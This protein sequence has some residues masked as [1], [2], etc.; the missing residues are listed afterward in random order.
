MICLNPSQNQWDSDIDGMSTPT[1]LFDWNFRPVLCQSASKWIFTWRVS[2]SL[3][4]TSGWISPVQGVFVSIKACHRTIAA[5]ASPSSSSSSV[6]APRVATTTS[7]AA[8]GRRSNGGDMKRSGGRR[9][10]KCRLVTLG[11]V[12]HP[13]SGY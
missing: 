8:F 2:S 11:R 5:S 6:C 12:L 7:L 1:Q 13:M 3:P 4:E 9:S 10:T